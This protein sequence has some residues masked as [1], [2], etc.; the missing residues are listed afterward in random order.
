MIEFFAGH[1]IWFHM[2]L[3]KETAD[4]LSGWACQEYFFSHGRFMPNI[5]TSE[6]QGA[7]T[8]ACFSFLWLEG[9]S[10]GIQPSTIEFQLI[11]SSRLAMSCFS[12]F[13]TTSSPVFKIIKATYVRDIFIHL[14]SLQA[15]RA[16]AKKTL[17]CIA[18]IF[19]K[20]SRPTKGNHDVA[21]TARAPAIDQI[22]TVRR[23][24]RWSDLNFDIEQSNLP[25]AAPPHLLY[26]RP[27]PQPSRP[28]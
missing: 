28:C 8:S 13:R 14:A 17:T 11:D 21:H 24:R 10:T 16:D 23:S 26:P 19:Y 4:F 22:A 20:L 3:A 7:T 15:T 6:S 27:L 5:S 1:K 18:Q 2:V 9:W 25:Y 12:N